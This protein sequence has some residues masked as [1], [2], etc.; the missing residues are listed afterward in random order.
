M[1]KFSSVNH[2]D[3]DLI[4]RLIAPRLVEAEEDEPAEEPEVFPMEPGESF[5]K[6]IQRRRALL[7]QQR[8]QH[9]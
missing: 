8:H 9:A 2:K 4:A 6:F 1:D 7:H 3:H 5:P